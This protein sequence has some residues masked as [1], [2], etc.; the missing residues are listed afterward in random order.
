MRIDFIL[1]LYL[2]V[3]IVVDYVL[4]IESLKK[5]LIISYFLVQR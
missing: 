2:F 1:L 3:W 5:G 4:A